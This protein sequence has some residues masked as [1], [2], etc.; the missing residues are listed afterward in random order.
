MKN[1][2]PYKRPKRKFAQAK[3]P[4]EGYGKNAWR[5][6]DALVGE[7]EKNELHKVVDF[8]KFN[9]IAIVHHSSAIEGSTLTYEETALLLT[10]GITAK[11][12]PMSEHEMVKD[13]YGALL[14]CLTPNPSPKERGTLKRE[15]T[16]KH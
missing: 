2:K 11:G 15:I 10:E 9:R 5:K 8:E 13:H 1:K 12:K 7:F 16:P 14:F 4:A 3:E 6:L